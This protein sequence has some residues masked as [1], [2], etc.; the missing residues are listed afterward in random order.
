MTY[1]PRAGFI[2][3]DTFIYTISDGQG[4]LSTAIVTIT[5]L[6]DPYMPPSSADSYYVP[7]YDW[8]LPYPDIRQPFE[9]ALFVLPAVEQ[10]RLDLLQIDDE[11]ARYGLGFAGEIR[12]MTL[13][14]GQGMVPAQYVLT[15]GVA[16]SRALSAEAAIQ[17]RVAEN[18]LLPGAETL[19]DDFSPFRPAVTPADG[20]GD[21]C[22]A[23]PQ[24]WR[25]RAELQRAA[26][27]RSG[28]PPVGREGRE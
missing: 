18:S 12:A 28:R 3:S 21:A 17:A 11:T 25:G 9:P 15:Q 4:G 26:A 8:R 6:A 7:P 13:R 23:M 27:R 24:P 14:D 19:F 22:L 1:T 10:A 20:H 5:V 16:Y 2:G